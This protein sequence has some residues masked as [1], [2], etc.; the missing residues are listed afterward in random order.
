MLETL[1][2]ESG[3]SLFG[4]MVF[5]TLSGVGFVNRVE[6][7][8]DPVKEMEGETLLGVSVC[9]PVVTVGQS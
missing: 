3:A 5:D 2:E 6:I 4:E 7:V 1:N 8:V 9:D